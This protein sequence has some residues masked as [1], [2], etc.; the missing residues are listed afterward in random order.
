MSKIKESAQKY[1]PFCQLFEE[2][3][4]SVGPS[5]RASE[6]LGPSGSASEDLGF[7]FRKGQP[8]PGFRPFPPC[9]RGRR[10]EKAAC[11]FTDEAHH[12]PFDESAQPR[13]QRG[14]RRTNLFDHYTVRVVR[15][16]SRAFCSVGSIST[17][18][19]APEPG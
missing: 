11:Y 8:L 3:L 12:Q 4:K 15:P 14:K 13:M 7:A 17:P 9:G 16:R 10:A 19:F 5:S 6:G 1:D 18:A 2:L